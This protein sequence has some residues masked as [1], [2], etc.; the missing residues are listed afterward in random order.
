MLSYTQHGNGDHILIFLHFFGSSGREWVH[1]IDRLS[2]KYR[3]IAADMPGFGDA[4]NIPGYTVSDMAAYVDELVRHFAPA[5]VT[6]VAHSFSGKVS[7]VVAATAPANLQRLV[8][9]AP[10]PLVP[11]P[12]DEAGRE[13][14]TLAN[15]T[16]ERINTFVRNS[17]YNDLSKEDFASAVADVHRANPAAWLA[18][19][20]SGSREDWS[21]RITN[22]QVP[23][24]LVIGEHD[25]SIP[26]TFQLEH[27]LPLIERTGGKLT[28][29]KGA[30][31]LLPFE[32]VDE[33]V[34]LISH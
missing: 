4:A 14:M 16:P 7:M 19:P 1:V 10:S 13:K 29:I 25:H 31:H 18:W 5:P 12:V 27:T 34:T 9:V 6:L 17:A 20:Q 24:D 2:P 28:V 23:T 32:A 30:A 22:L 21:T 3:C 33:L 8:L 26:L 15:T 11:E